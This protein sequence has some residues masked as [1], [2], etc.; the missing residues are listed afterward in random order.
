M[1]EIKYYL[2]CDS[3]KNK[4]MKNGLIID[5]DGNQR[6]YLNGK[7]HRV[8]GPA[9]IHTDGTQSWWLNGKLHR[10]DGPAIIFANGDKAWYLNGKCHREDRPAVISI[11]GY[12]E[13]WING[14]EISNEDIIE[15]QEQYN[16]PTNH[17]NWNDRDK[18]LFKLHFS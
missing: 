17:E 3:L 4:K 15:W 16:I 18:M 7:Y 2:I 1:I 6:W 5:A 13:Y 12:Q 8:D 14:N 9:I 11:N 10:V